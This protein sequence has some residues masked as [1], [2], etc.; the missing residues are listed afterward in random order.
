MRIRLLSLNIWDLP[1]PFP[2]LHRRRRRS[3]LV[4]LLPGLG[5]D[6]ILIQEAFI[7]RFRELLADKLSD[8]QCDGSLRASRGVGPLRMDAS[9]GLLTFSRWPIV[10]SRFLP[11]TPVPR[12]RIDERIGRKG[13]LWSEVETPAGRLL[14]GNTHLHAGLSVFNAR[15]R[16]AQTRDLLDQWRSLAQRPTVLAGDFNMT[17]ELE[18]PGLHPTGFDVLSGAGFTEIAG[19]SST[20]LATMA[21][22]RNPYARFPPFHRLDRRLTQV[23]FQGGVRSG[24]S[25]RPSAS[26]PPQSPIILG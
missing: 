1:V 18:R 26:T 22:S 25:G 14:V 2:G 9:G 23:F 4:Q 3:L 17:A 13:G 15:A 21:P 10:W 5:A 12:S 7:P 20:Q 16:T 19:G 11:F 6:L 8:Y 24:P